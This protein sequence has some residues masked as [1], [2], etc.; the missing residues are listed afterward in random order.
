ME[1]ARCVI[2]KAFL[3]PL[4]E[5]VLEDF[6]SFFPKLENDFLRERQA[7]SGKEVLDKQQKGKVQRGNKWKLI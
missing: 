2:C 3:S 7:A 4:H 6:G 5:R 1:V